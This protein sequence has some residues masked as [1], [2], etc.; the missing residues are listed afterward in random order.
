MTFFYDKQVHNNATLQTSSERGRGQTLRKVVS[1]ISL[2]DSGDFG[3]ADRFERLGI[4][5]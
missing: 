3:C 1:F 2:K 4:V 5:M